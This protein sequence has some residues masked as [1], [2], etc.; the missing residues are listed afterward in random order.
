MPKAYEGMTINE[1]N[2]KLTEIHSEQKRIRA[3][4]KEVAAILDKLLTE[5]AVRDKLA[6]MSDAERMALLQMIQADSIASESA[7]GAPGVT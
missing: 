4:K 2:A 1:L 7:V 5:K 6:A 3:E